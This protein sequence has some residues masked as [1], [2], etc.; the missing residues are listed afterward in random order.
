VRAPRTPRFCYIAFPL[1]S[2]RSKP[3]LAWPLPIA[4]AALA[5]AACAASPAEQALER[6]DRAALHDV[7]SARERAGSL[8]NRE[9][10]RLARAV[11]ESELRTASGAD[12]VDRVR[13]ARPCAHELDDALAARMRTHDSAGAQAAL[14]RID[15][16]GL[17]LEDAREL[18]GDADPQWR[19]VAARSLVRGE[20]RD[21]RQR[22]LVDPEPHVRREAA[23]AARDA[24]DLADLGAL[25]EAARVDPEP[26]VRTEA[27][28]AIA[29]LPAEADREVALSLRDLWR[30]GDDGLREDI[31]LA[32]SSDAMWTTGGRDELRHVVAS[33]HGPGAVE[34]AAV[35]LRHHDADAELVQLAL[36]QLERAIDASAPVARATRLQAIAQAPLDRGGV[37]NAVQK[38]AADDDLA[39]R[40]AALA[41]LAETRTAGA[42]EAL[43]SLARPDS[44]VASH[45]RFALAVSGDRRVQA[46]I[47]QDLGAEP[48]DLRLAAAMELAALGVAARGAPLL[49]DPDAR[50]RLRAACTMIRAARVHRP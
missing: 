15:G 11:A 6:G 2:R 44:P 42:I 35:V 47:E 3:L 14:A 9:A 32:W 37:L 45:A 48:S 18:A 21:A 20:D 36:G 25:F 50:V 39:L 19:A 10:E 5:A 23:R 34:A 43:E 7:I 26:I 12:A 29:A 4:G 49:A 22:C 13:D 46:W 17:R 33:E 27:V 41:R 40:V 28:R 24:K 30:S 8:S 38:A 31:A 1:V 16:G